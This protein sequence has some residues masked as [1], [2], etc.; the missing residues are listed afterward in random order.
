M[1]N[2]IETRFH[3]N[4]AISA[5]MELVNEISQFV[6][7]KDKKDKIAWSVF[8]EG[9]EATVVLLSPVVPHVT[10]TLWNIMGHKGNLLNASWPVHN[11]DALK[12][13]TKLVI[14]QVN[15]KVRNKIEV[16]SALDEKQIEEKA[17]TDERILKFID[18][19]TIK[20]VIVVQ[21]KLVNIVV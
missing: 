1:T 20:K 19:K 12:V 17:L 11:E 2:D 21:K 10:E 14:L 18:G 15:G 5:V 9:I 3:F 16:D 13:Q 7:S 8:R 6:N 4:T